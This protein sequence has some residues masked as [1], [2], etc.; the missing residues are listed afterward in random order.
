MSLF[1]CVK[2]L[3]SSVGVM[4]CSVGIISKRD[5]CCAA[6]AR[7]IVWTSL[8]RPS[9]RATHPSHTPQAVELPGEFGPR[10]PAD[11]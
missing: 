9:P 6:M 11:D 1:L 8:T 7:V 2:H 4:A 3:Q 10:A 5:S